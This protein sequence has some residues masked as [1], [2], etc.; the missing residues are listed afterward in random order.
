MADADTAEKGRQ[1]ECTKCLYM[2]G[3]F[4]MFCRSKVKAHIFVSIFPNTN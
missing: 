2:T 3:V 1:E 4:C